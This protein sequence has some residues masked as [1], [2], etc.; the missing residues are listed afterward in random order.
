MKDKEVLEIC[1]QHYAYS[2]QPGTV[3]LNICEEGLWH[4][5]CL[6]LKI[7]T[8]GEEDSHGKSQRQNQ[9]KERKQ[10]I[11]KM[12]SGENPGETQVP[13]AGS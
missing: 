1:Y 10:C 12:E 4:L 8:G 13:S 11:L 5:L 3:H 9:S 7:K 2:E 6:L